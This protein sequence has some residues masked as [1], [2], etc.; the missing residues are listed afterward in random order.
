MRWN[1]AVVPLAIV[2]SLL[3]A[4]LLGAYA[5]RKGML[6]MTGATDPDNVTQ[7]IIRALGRPDLSGLQAK[8]VVGAA[9]PVSRPTSRRPTSRRPTAV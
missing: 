1:R 3:I 5:I 2:V 4:M 8:V 6:V 7:T 9:N